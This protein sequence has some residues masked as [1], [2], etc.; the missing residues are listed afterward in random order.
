[1]ASRA[2]AMRST[3]PA[4]PLSRWTVAVAVAV[5]ALVLAHVADSYLVVPEGQPGCSAAF[6]G[7]HRY[8]AGSTGV[9][10][11]LWWQPQASTSGLLSLFSDR[12]AGGEFW[13][14][15]RGHAFATAAGCGRVCGCACLLQPP[16]LMRRAR[17]QLT[18]RAGACLPCRC[19]VPAVAAA[20]T[21]VPGQPINHPCLQPE[22]CQRRGPEHR[23]RVYTGRR[24]SEPHHVHVGGRHRPSRRVRARSVVVL[25]VLR[26]PRPQP[27]GGVRARP[28]A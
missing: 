1:M 26:R 3:P 10:V 6:L 18:P 16:R 12:T 15:V 23:L 17:V 20:A 22:P 9:T 19:I 28:R 8:P 11:E 25:S 21:V 7:F 5:S 24:G 4:L 13:N 27:P 2:R 14:M